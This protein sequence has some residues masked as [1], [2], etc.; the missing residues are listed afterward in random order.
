VA[1]AD[2][3]D[4]AEH[5]EGLV[6]SIATVNYEPAV[7]S[8]AWAKMRVNRMQE[9]MIGYTLGRRHFDADPR[10]SEWR[11]LM[12]AARTRSGFPPAL[13]EGSQ[14]RTSNFRPSRP[15]YDNAEFTL[16]SKAG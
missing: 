5:F 7:R 13:R 10:I 11:R 4:I 1:A 9:F 2:R 6:K 12:H 3:H 8:G 14:I 15:I 16:M